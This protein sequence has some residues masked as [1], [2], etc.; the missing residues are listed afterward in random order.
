MGTKALVQ[1]TLM[2]LGNS[3]YEFIYIMINTH[4]DIVLLCVSSTVYTMF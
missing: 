3:A 4:H 2:H 1:R